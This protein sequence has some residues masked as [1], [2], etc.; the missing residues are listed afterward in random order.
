VQLRAPD[1]LME[2]HC[3]RNSAMGLAESIQKSESRAVVAHQVREG[4]VEPLLPL[5]GVGS[6]AAMV[7]Y[8]A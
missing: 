3:T 8:L 4:F 6:I 1:S 7:P 5:S 2:M